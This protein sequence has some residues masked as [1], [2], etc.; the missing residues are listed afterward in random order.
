M[1]NIK[2]LKTKYNVLEFTINYKNSDYTP[3]FFKNRLK[4]STE[5]FYKINIS[6]FFKVDKDL[7]YNVNRLKELLKKITLIDEDKEY[8]VFLDSCSDVEVEEDNIILITFNCNGKIY[9]K[10]VKKKI[11][12]GEKIEFNSVRDI[13][14]NFSL[15]ATNISSE[16]NVTLNNM[17]FKFNT[18]TG[19]EI[20][21]EEGKVK[22]LIDWDFY[23]FI[24]S[25]NKEFTL[26][27]EGI[28]EVYIDYREE[29]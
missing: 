19:F 25:K 7:I 22:D 24:K 8:D 12:N 11:K 27:L 26:K 29:L 2:E 10:R 16:K 5:N 14:L 18:K 15:E 23:E 4:S 20:N 17:I 28:N 6:C 13:K 21:A 9:R 3:E 1:I